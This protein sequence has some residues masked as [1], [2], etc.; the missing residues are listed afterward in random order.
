MGAVLPLFARKSKKVADLIPEL[1]LHGVAVQGKCP[2]K[3]PA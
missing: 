1:Y 3:R 2:F